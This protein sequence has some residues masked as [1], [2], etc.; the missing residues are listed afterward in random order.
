M[1]A[2]MPV[3]TED[4]TNSASTPERVRENSICM[5]PPRHTATRNAS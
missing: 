5:T 3:M 1:A 2:S 4:G